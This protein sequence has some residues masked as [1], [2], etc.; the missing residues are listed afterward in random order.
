MTIYHNTFDGWTTY[1][2]S[3]NAAANDIASTEASMENHISTMRLDEDGYKVIV[4]DVS[5]A[6]YQQ[7]LEIN[8][9]DEQEGIYDRQHNDSLRQPSSVA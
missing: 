1:H 6:A 2:T 9:E 5:Q 8:R 3:F 4:L 7:A